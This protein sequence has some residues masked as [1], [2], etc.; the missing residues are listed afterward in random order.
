[1][2]ERAVEHGTTVQGLVGQEVL[3]REDRR[4]LIG[5]GRFTGDLAPTGLLHVAFVRSP[6]AHAQVRSVTAE[7]ARKLPGVVGV[8]TGAGLRGQVA[9]LPCH[10]VLPGMTVPTHL[11]L[12]VDTVRF[13]G[14][15]VAAVVAEDP[16]VAADAAAA[17]QVDYRPLPAVT[18]VTTAGRPDAPLVHAELGR[19][20]A[21]RFPGRG[22]NYARAA[23]H[24][25]I[26]LRQRLINQNIVPAALEPRSVLA[27]YDR[28]TGEL[29]VYS[30]TQSPHGI[31]RSLAEVLGFPEQRLRVVAPDVG[32]GFGAKLHLYPEEVVC[33]FLARKLGRPVRWTATRSEDFAATNHGRDHVQDLELCARRDGTITG[34]KAVLHA[35]LGA[36]LSGMGPGVPAVNCAFMLTGTYRIPNVDVVTHGMLTHT[37]RVDTYRGA[38]HPEATYLIERAVD[39]LAAELHLDP[40]EIRRRNF[41]PPDAFPYR[42]PI[43]G[44]AYDSGNYEP[45]LAKALD[46][47]DYPRSAPPPA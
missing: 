37:S 19:N 25:D 8:V 31:R 4:H 15:A 35:N 24:A 2:T 33:A 45:A 1:M 32:G 20:E 17:V 21:F 10:W 12:A 40:A 11:A 13:Q 6:H 41:I 16:Y 9:P 43:R 30:S 47:V 26:R 38:G 28:G 7:P 34:L 44:F 42:L 36:Y 5:Q 46:L 18:D 3:R 27:A 29:T 14:E 23:R 39:L 22:G